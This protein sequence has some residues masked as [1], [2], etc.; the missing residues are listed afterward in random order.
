MFYSIWEFTFSF[1][2]LY[3]LFHKQGFSEADCVQISYVL[4]VDWLHQEII[5]LDV[6]QDFKTYAGLGLKKR[7]KDFDLIDA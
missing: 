6:V 3:F 2:Q 4:D 7:K 5:V 1:Y